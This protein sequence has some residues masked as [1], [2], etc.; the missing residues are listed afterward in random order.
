MLDTTLTAFT[1]I[2]K[3]DP[4]VSPAARSAILKNIRNSGKTHEKPADPLNRPLIIRRG[5]A[6]KL[7][8]VSTRTIDKWAQ[9][10][11]LTKVRLK[12][13]KRSCGFKSDEIEG[14]IKASQ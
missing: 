8:G 9:E 14:L 4:S 1:A 7:Y 3:T 5:D 11:L 12:D 6:A 13:R 2:L 10:G